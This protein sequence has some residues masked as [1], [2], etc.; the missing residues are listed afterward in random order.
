MTATLNNK[1]K[2]MSYMPK[3]LETA[4]SKIDVAE[5]RIMTGDY[6]NVEAM[7]SFFER[8]RERLLG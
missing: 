7:L 3:K 4:L 5:Q 8:K 2:N 1:N 6:K